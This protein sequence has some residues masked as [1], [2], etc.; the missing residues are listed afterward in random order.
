MKHISNDKGLG[1]FCKNTILC[2][3]FVCT[4]SGEII[5]HEEGLKRAKEQ[6]KKGKSNYILFVKEYFSSQSI[7][8]VIDPTVIGNIGRHE[9]LNG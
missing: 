9:I 2:G 1:I 5:G 3:S 8:T 6:Q 4:Y 7:S